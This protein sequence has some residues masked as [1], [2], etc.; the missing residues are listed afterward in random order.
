MKINNNNLVENMNKNIEGLKAVNAK[1]EK[2]Q[3]KLEKYE[4]EEKTYINELRETKGFFVV[5]PNT[6]EY[7]KIKI[8]DD[9][10]KKLN[11]SI[12]TLQIEKNII[13]NNI[14]NIINYDFKFNIIY[15]IE[16]F[17]YKNIGE[18]TTEKI[19]NFVN[20]YFKNTYNILTKF[21][22]KREYNYYG[23]I[24]YINFE[25]HLYKN[26]ENLYNSFLKYTTTLHFDFKP[27]EIR[28]LVGLKFT[29]IDAHFIYNYD[30]G[31]NFETIDNPKE[32]AKKIKNLNV[33]LLAK[34]EK[35]IKELEQIKEDNNKMFINNLYNLT[36]NRIN[37]Y[38]RRY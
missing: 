34:K 38:I 4:T 29:D 32:E 23:S 25:I 5:K 31:L 33:K 2:Q 37:E 18:K 14:Y 24:S 1:I 21:Y 27:Y 30:E 7:E 10:I 3:I 8:F 16:P 11:D 19:Q 9:C 13:L 26:K 35:I 15:K 36:D 28:D 20:D 6:P 17:F 22:F 12:N